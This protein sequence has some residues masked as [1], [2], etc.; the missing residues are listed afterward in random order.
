[1]TLNNDNMLLTLNEI[2]SEFLQNDNLVLD[3]NMTASDIDGWDSLSHIQ[4][5]HLC[6]KKLS[7]RFTLGEISNLK[8]VG[9]LVDLM[10]KYNI[11]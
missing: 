8:T 6:E 10:E 1:M 2:V 7:K 5:V 9:D 11:K 3:R 4:I